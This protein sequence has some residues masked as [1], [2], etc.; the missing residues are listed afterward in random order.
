M[1]D[2]DDD[3]VFELS[4]ERMKIVVGGFGAVVFGIPPV[5]MMVVDERAIEN[6]AVMRLECVERS[7]WRRR[8][9]CGRRKKGRAGLRNRL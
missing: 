3:I 1:F 5:E 2:L 9:A 8:R 7:R 4:V 6:D